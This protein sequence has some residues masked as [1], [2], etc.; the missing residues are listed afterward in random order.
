[1]KNL[2][3]YL[4]IGVVTVTTLFSCNN[5]VEFTPDEQQVEIT[6]EDDL[7]ERNIPFY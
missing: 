3:F 5:T 7:I 4:M 2:I 6:R 1:M